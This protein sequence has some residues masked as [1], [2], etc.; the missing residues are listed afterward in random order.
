MH[1]FV[2]TIL[3]VLFLFLISNGDI[4][5]ALKVVCRIY[6]ACGVLDQSHHTASG[7]GQTGSSLRHS[8]KQL[9]LS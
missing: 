8:S 9:K 4:L 7:G 2:C 5:V 6:I 3:N 1:R